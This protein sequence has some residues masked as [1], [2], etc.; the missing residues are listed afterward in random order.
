M[1]FRHP[2]KVMLDSWGVFDT[3]IQLSNQAIEEGKVSRFK[4]L[5]E[6]VHEN[7]F[8]FNKDWRNYKADTIKKTTKTEEAFNAE[9]VEGEERVKNFP[10]NDSW[11]KEQMRV[12][13]DT[14]E[15]LETGDTPGSKGASAAGSDEPDI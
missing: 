5:S 9:S 15:K 8:K 11:A 6:L 13:S 4:N 10:Y 7:F 3:A 1:S 12:Y 14:M 2:D